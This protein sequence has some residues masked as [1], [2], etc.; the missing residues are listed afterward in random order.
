[1]DDQTG[2]VGYLRY[3]VLNGREPSARTYG[4]L[5][6]GFDE[7]LSYRERTIE[8]YLTTDVETYKRQLG[9][10]S[11]NTA[12]IFLAAIRDTSGGGQDPSPDQRHDHARDAAIEPFRNSSRE[13][14]ISQFTEDH[15]KCG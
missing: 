14:A 4:A 5:L 9:L 10:R 11:A 6:R 7:W 2:I 8:D 13:S 15:C 12:N 1:M 3:L